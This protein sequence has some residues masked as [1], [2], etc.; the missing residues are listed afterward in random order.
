MNEK[1]TNSWAITVLQS[2][3]M[4]DFLANITALCNQ[5]QG[6]YKSYVGLNVLHGEL[7]SLKCYFTF[8]SEI[9][10]E[11]IA[12]VLGAKSTE[13]FK[14]EYLNRSNDFNVIN[15]GSG[16][17][18]AIK[19]SPVKNQPVYGLYFKVMEPEPTEFLALPESKQYAMLHHKT[20]EFDGSKMIYKE[21]DVNQNLIDERNLYY[22][23][24]AAY[25]QVLAD[26]FKE[27]Y[28]NKAHQIEYCVS[29]KD[30]SYRKINLLMDLPAYQNGYKQTSRGGLLDNALKELTLFQHL[31]PVC[32]GFYQG[33]ATNSIYLINTLS[34]TN[35]HIN[36]VEE[37][38]EWCKSGRVN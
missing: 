25:K 19:F 17:T 28:I 21:F 31:V 1:K 2:P 5:Q 14:H 33:N 37:V 10:P 7:V 27:P 20:P 15:G 23:K 12:M 24:E 26:W 13:Y 36:T 9:L 6:G 18:F 4:V 16:Y 34:I 8:F 30:T 35:A 3:F 22:I 38:V 32:P 11:Q 29:A